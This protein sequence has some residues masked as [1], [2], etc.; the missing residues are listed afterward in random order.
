MHPVELASA[1]GLLVGT[2]LLRD[3]HSGLKMRERPKR[4]REVHRRTLWPIRGREVHRWTLWPK[5][6]REVHLNSQSSIFISFKD[7]KH[8]GT[9]ARRALIFL[10]KYLHSRAQHNRKEKMAQVALEVWSLAPPKRFVDI[11]LRIY[12]EHISR[13]YSSWLI[14]L[15]SFCSFKQKT[16]SASVL[17]ANDAA[18]AEA[19]NRNWLLGTAQ[20]SSATWNP[21]NRNNLGW[22]EQIWISDSQ[23]ANNKSQGPLFLPPCWRRKTDNFKLQIKKYKFQ[24]KTLPKALRTQALTTLTS[25][26]GLVGLV[27]YAW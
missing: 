16:F 20:I 15:I 9:H 22:F 17:E 19:D 4:G 7:D 13:L 12:G 10:Q 21:T 24:I 23:I 25:N 6:E 1:V 26:F 8:L 3:E 18:S 27:Q 14:S 11:R 2:L 5:N